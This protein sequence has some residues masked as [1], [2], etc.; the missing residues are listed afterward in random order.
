ML[1]EPI[2]DMALPAWR[3]WYFPHDLFLVFLDH[4]AHAKPPADNDGSEQPVRAGSELRA[5]LAKQCPDSTRA[6]TVDF[7]DLALPSLGPL[8][9]ALDALRGLDDSFRNIEVGTSA[10]PRAPL[11]PQTFS[12][13]ITPA[14]KSDES[15]EL[16]AADKVPVVSAGF[17]ALAHLLTLFTRR[18]SAFYQRHA[19][20]ISSSVAACIDLCKNAAHQTDRQRSEY[21]SACDETAMAVEM[22]RS[23][24]DVNLSA[25][26]SVLRAVPRMLGIT[27]VSPLE[28]V[29]ARMPFGP[30]RQVSGLAR[31]QR[32]LVLNRR[33]GY[34]RRAVRL[35]PASVL[36]L[37][38]SVQ[39]QALQTPRAANVD[40]D[41]DD[42]DG[43]S[44]PNPYA[45]KSFTPWLRE[46]AVFV[47][48]MSVICGVEYAGLGQP[49]T[50]AGGARDA[51]YH[52][53]LAA[54]PVLL[55]AIFACC[56][57]AWAE[58][59]VNY[60]FLFSLD[61]RAHF[62][63]GDIMRDALL[64]AGALVVCMYAF[65]R[66]AV[67]E[68]RARNDPDAIDFPH[69]ATFGYLVWPFYAL[70]TIG[71]IVRDAR[72]ATASKRARE[73][74]RKP[75][76][77]PTLWRVVR[78]PFLPV[79][80]SDFIVCACTVTLGVGWTQAQYV[81]CHISE[82]SVADECATGRYM[83]IQAL[84]LVPLLWRLAQCLR[85]YRVSPRPRRGFPHLVN[86][87]KY[88]VAVFGL[89]TR[90][91]MQTAVHFIDD[92]THPA[93]TWLTV[94]F[95][96]ARSA[97]SCFR[98]GW[99]LSVD[100]GLKPYVD[101][102][103]A[104]EVNRSAHRRS[105]LNLDFEA[106]RH[107]GPAK[108]ATSNSL[109]L[110]WAVRPLLFPR[111][112]YLLFVVVDVCVRWAWLLWYYLIDQLAPKARWVPFVMIAA[113]I[114]RRALWLA[115]RVENEQ[116]NNIELYKLSQQA[117]PP[118][119]PIHQFLAE[120]PPETPTRSHGAQRDERI[121]GLWDA[122]NASFTLM[123][124][125]AVG[126]AEDRSTPARRSPLSS[127]APTPVERLLDSH[128]SH[129]FAAERATSFAGFGDNNS[130]VTFFAQ[131]PSS[132]RYAIATFIAASEPLVG[133]LDDISAPK[134]TTDENSGRTA[135]FA[136]LPAELQM[137]G[138]LV[139]VGR[140]RTFA[141]YI[142]AT[143]Q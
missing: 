101:E 116:V 109:W 50:V 25:V 111:W 1:A 106:Q 16:E 37:S 20:V 44:K 19:Q 130:L 77:L 138:L 91:A 40:E 31:L 21:A 15:V 120:P 141:Q 58:V 54:S 110:P 53:T 143:C 78:T 61:Y 102:S 115:V 94:L 63:G 52:F 59:G 105:L 93:R 108:A 74:V 29:M 114:L 33:R 42:S 70:V 7:V 84:R 57:W 125:A 9:L 10:D 132:E 47:A 122:N 56:T 46:L 43:D 71:I 137:Y 39:Q 67:A 133:T 17:A 112:F 45:S 119:V 14:K 23:Y 30:Q 136:S 140:D 66:S 103:R 98:L 28:L 113:A 55:G 107:G 80:F 27:I 118:P 92:P 123:Q 76:L 62:T 24:R 83:K 13:H 99:D 26:R 49:I 12:L 117:P 48:V 75:W 121:A 127:V 82:P 96:A 87:A 64:Y 41:S 22:L 135:Y 4:A 60:P 72:A 104:G 128:G 79:T 3:A 81:W 88:G 11:D 68:R 34:G 90:F 18:V 38:E 5:A 36:D 134:F 73:P 69:A 131:L 2:L 6:R 51:A 97:D 129:S 142:D 85:N 124:G 139:R 8:V 35:A 126:D 95:F 89:L 65:L 86:A 100:C 32:L